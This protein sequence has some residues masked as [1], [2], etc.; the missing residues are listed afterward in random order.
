MQVLA[1]IRKRL[2]LNV[3]RS[4]RLEI[5]LKRFGYRGIAVPG[6][7]M[8][9]LALQGFLA[10]GGDVAGG[11]DPRSGRDQQKCNSENRERAFPQQPLR[12]ARAQRQIPDIRM[13]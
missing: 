6:G 13:A 5:H 12:R 10:P 1:I 9:G 11:V 7:A 8:A 2:F 4:Q 3:G